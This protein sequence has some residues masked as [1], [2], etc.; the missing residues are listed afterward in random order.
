MKSIYK[1]TFYPSNKG[2]FEKDFLEAADQDS[3]VERIIKIEHYRHLFACLYYIRQDGMLA[4]YYPD[5]MLKI[6]DEIFVVET[7]GK[8][9]GTLDWIK[10]INELK[11]DDRM[12]TEWSYVL[13][14][15][16][17]FYRHKKQNANIKEILDICK[18]TRNISEGVLF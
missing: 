16:S 5:F 2:K 17:D 4:P 12:N 18:L 15:D 10:R 13:L 6:G 7:K 3:K 14:T 1:Q 9:S 11:P 8:E